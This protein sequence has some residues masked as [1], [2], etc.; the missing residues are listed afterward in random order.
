MIKKI[1]EYLVAIEK[2]A[3]PGRPKAYLDPRAC[4]RPSAL[5]NIT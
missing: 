1:A 3:P 2:L 5:E 4:Q